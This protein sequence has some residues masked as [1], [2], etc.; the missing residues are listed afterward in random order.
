MNCLSRLPIDLLVFRPFGEYKNQR[1]RIPYRTDRTEVIF[2]LVFVAIRGRRQI[3][4][5]QKMIG[6][7]IFFAP[8]QH[9]KT[10]IKHTNIFFNDSP[11]REMIH[12]LMPDAVSS[13]HSNRNSKKLYKIII[14]TRK[15]QMGIMMIK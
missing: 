14:K 3:S 4:T 10:Q 2:P 6:F 5:T 11:D 8:R 15:M 13:I 7:V 1:Y 9:T 12:Q